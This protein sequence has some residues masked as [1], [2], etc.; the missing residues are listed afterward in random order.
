MNNKK[1]KLELPLILV[2]AVAL[3]MIVANIILGIV[4]VEQ[5][6]KNMKSLIE[7]RM[8]DVAN[9]AAD[10]LNGDDLSRLKRQDMNTEVFKKIND[11]L[12]IFQNN[13]ELEYIYTVKY[14]GD[15]KFTFMV[16]PA[17]N[18]NN[19]GDEVVFTDAL[20]EA[21]LGTPS[22]DKKPYTDQWGRFYSAYS[23]VYNSAGKVA[24][25]VAV[26]FNADWYDSMV[27]G[28]IRSIV[29]GVILSLLICLIFLFTASTYTRKR[30]KNINSELDNAFE[31]R[32][33][34]S[35]EI[36]RALSADY[37]CVHYIDIDKD[38]AICVKETGEG[39]DIHVGDHFPYHQNILKYADFFI[40]EDYKE[41]F[42]RIAQPNF[43]R[44][45]LRND[46]FISFIYLISYNRKEMFVKI[47]FA[48]VLRN[49]E[50]N[51]APVRAVALSITDVDEETR[52]HFN[53][54]RELKEALEKAEK[55][56]E[57]KANLLLGISYEIRTPLN[58]LVK[59][60]RKAIADIEVSDDVKAELK[61]AGEASDK[62]LELMDEVLD[63][64]S[65]EAGQIRIKHEEYSF[66]NLL[67]HVN[68]TIG[69]KCEN[70]GVIYEHRI[71]GN[72]DGNYIGDPDRIYQCLVIIL[73]NAV[74]YTPEGL[75][76]TFDVTELSKRDRLTM[77]QF[78][79]SDSGLGLS[80]GILSRM[81]DPYNQE[82]GFT[83]DKYG[84]SGLGMPLTKELIELMDG[85][86]EVLGGDDRNTEF[87]IK[88]PL[89]E[90]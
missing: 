7:S 73:S 72:L 29:L 27:S 65:I 47:N 14:A 17:E 53:K 62:L 33:S 13:I 78:N 24:A 31:K 45:R 74:K 76:V 35:A 67:E 25:I 56:N 19:F 4:L 44:E 30:L 6:K 9:V 69:N 86:I 12:T 28:E 42:L 46:P 83:E 58:Q 80:E 59:T 38:E 43:L 52:F 5:S 75:K 34:M 64:S 8:L 68:L 81:F 10:M 37:Y 85:S 20:Y 77:V 11:T 49:G 41:E 18:S 32:E 84:S 40:H 89:Y 66:S 54:N 55:A 61:E 3:L 22:V 26:D 90:A 88:L 51:D 16:D 23:P 39:D 50:R 82:S 15:D 36:N 63:L 71:S 70:K 2:V 57:A 60:G 1:P 21:S 48:R 79:I 87:I